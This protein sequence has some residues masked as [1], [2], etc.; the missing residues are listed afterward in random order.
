M[1]ALS[2]TLIAFIGTQVLLYDVNA[3]ALLSGAAYS[4][5]DYLIALRSSTIPFKLIF[6]PWFVFFCQISL[7]HD[8]IS[9]MVIRQQSRNV[10]WDIQCVKMALFSVI[11]AAFITICGLALALPH[12][13][14]MINWNLE[15][16]V[17]ARTV[18]ALNFDTQWWHVVMAM[19]LSCSISF[20]GTGLLFLAIW[21]ITDNPLFSW[22]SVIALVCWDSFF[23][24]EEMLNLSLLYN[25]IPLRYMQ[26]QNQSLWLDGSLAALFCIALYLTG[27]FVICRRKEFY[28]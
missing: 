14:G 4:T 26:W 23:L 18:Y 3:L 5:V 6:L 13:S 17:Y 22:M 24:G 2:G 11:W 12:A 21:W 27:R 28:R 7:Q 25:R 16:S 10:I 20:M 1:V 19:F 9:A 15:N 8:F